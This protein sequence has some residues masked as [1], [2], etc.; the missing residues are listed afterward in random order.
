MKQAKTAVCFDRGSS[1]Y[2]YL[3]YA[4]VTGPSCTFRPILLIQIESLWV[5]ALKNGG[6]EEQGPE[7]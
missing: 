4:D 3:L 2:G 1:D 7:Q 6:T 5:K